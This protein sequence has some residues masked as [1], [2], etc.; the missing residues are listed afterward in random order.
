MDTFVER[1]LREAER[2]DMSVSTLVASAG[3]NP[4]HFYKWKR[5]EAKPRMSTIKR[6]AASLQ[7]P[8][9]SLLGDA[10]IEGEDINEV[11]DSSKPNAGAASTQ[12]MR[13]FGLTDAAFNELAP[14]LAAMERDAVEV[15][16]SMSA[17]LRRVAVP[18]SNL[19]KSHQNCAVPPMLTLPVATW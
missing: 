11:S 14:L 7:I 18:F 17:A 5:G 16:A 2:R 13:F 15:P 19:S 3:V 4:S 6:L 8:V 12:S 9:K 1:I 10:S